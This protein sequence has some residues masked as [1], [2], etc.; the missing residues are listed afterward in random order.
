MVVSQFGV[1]VGAHDEESG[2]NG[3]PGHHV[4]QQEQ[5]RPGRPL[6]VVEHEED[7]RLA[8]GGGQPGGHGVEEPVTLGLGV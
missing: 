2:G 3:P 8:R 5:R 1:P 6:E 4:P 7:G